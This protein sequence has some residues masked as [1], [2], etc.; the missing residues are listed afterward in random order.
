MHLPGY[1]GWAE[2][3]VECTQDPVHQYIPAHQK[4]LWVVLWFLVES[5]ETDISICQ[6]PV[7]LWGVCFFMMESNLGHLV[8]SFLGLHIGQSRHCVFCY[9][10]AYHRQLKRLR[11]PLTVSVSHLSSASKFNRD[12]DWDSIGIGFSWLGPYR[13]RGE[14]FST[15]IV[16]ILIRLAKFLVD[17]KPVSLSTLASVKPLAVLAE[18]LSIACRSLANRSIAVSMHDPIE[19]EETRVGFIEL[20]YRSHEWFTPKIM[21]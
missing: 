6:P 18:R 7:P 10:L 21:V 19:S 12:W 4:L 16:S 17:D 2:W 14:L 1:I 5:Y 20:S 9:L 11:L 15:V 3:H 13:G 8:S